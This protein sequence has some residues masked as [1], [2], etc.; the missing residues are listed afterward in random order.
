MKTF[1]HNI[2][3]LMPLEDITLPSGIRH[4]VVPSGKHYPSV[5]TILGSIPNPALEQWKQRMGVEAAEKFAKLMARRGSN[6]HKIAEQ[7]LLN[8]ENYQ[9]GFMPDVL[10][11]FKS[12]LP[13][14]DNVDNIQAIESPLYSDVFKYAGRTDIIAE[15]CGVPSIIDF[16]TTN[17]DLEFSDKHVKYFCQCA[18]YSVAWK[19]LTNLNITQAVLIFAS[20]DFGPTV[21]IEKIDKTTSYRKMFLEAVLTYHKENPN[22]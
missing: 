20:N 12:L 16:K 7:Y 5:T 21:L 6:L 18:G 17:S 19:E 2:V 13:I 9:K 22:V 14:L 10:M 8:V 11:M 15:Y 3:E 1:T 4:Y